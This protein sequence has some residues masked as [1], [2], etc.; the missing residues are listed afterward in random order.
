[1]TFWTTFLAST[2]TTARGYRPPSL[3]ERVVGFIGRPDFPG[4]ICP[5]GTAFCLVTAPMPKEVP[6]LT[7]RVPGHVCFVMESEGVNDKRDY[8]GERVS[9]I[10]GNSA[11]TGG[12]G[13]NV[14][15]RP[16]AGELMVE[17]FAPTVTTSG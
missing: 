6:A 4:S 14:V 7:R 15:V 9:R 16:G 8:A 10:V 12:G 1:M 11:S 3:C 2:C 17:G 13:G 5:I